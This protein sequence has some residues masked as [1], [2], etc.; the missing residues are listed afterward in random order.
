MV[1]FF[2]LPC[3]I[4]GNFTD[5]EPVT[6]SN[7]EEISSSESQPCLQEFCGGSASIPRGVVLHKSFPNHIIEDLQFCDESSFVEDLQFCDES[8][9]VVDSKS[10]P[11][12]DCRDMEQRV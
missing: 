8:S 6:E 2:S 1:L 9:V 7:P 10:S 3:D 5:S 12:T 4:I 11:R